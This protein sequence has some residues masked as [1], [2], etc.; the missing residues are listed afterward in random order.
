MVDHLLNI[1]KVCNESLLEEQKYRQLIHQ[2]VTERAYGTFFACVDQNQGRKDRANE[3]LIDIPE[4]TNYQGKVMFA[5]TTLKK[6]VDVAVL[7]LL[8]LGLLS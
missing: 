5:W 8:F 7:W 4:K 1:E 2:M 3:E 6:Q